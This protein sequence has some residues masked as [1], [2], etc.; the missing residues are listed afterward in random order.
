MEITGDELDVVGNDPETN[1]FIFVDCFA[2]SPKGRRHICY[3]HEGQKERERKGVFP[4]GNAMDLAIV[5]GIEILTE[6]EYRNLQ[7]LE[8]FDLKSSSWIKH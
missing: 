1:Q 4:A 3:D 8:S 2:E 7:R 5:M 6:E